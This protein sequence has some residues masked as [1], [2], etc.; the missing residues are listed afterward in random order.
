MF[1]DL[2]AAF[3]EAAGVLLVGDIGVSIA[4]GTGF[5]TYGF[6]GAEAIS[7][8]FI[9]ENPFGA[10]DRPVRPVG[11]PPASGVVPSAPPGAPAAPPAAPAAA[12][13][14]PTA[15]RSP[16]SGPSRSCARRCTPSTGPTAPRA[17]WRRSG[18]S[19]C[20]PPPASRR[21]TGATSAVVSARVRGAA[22]SRRARRER[23]SD[24]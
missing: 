14:R 7:G 10:A 23:P 12:R 6:G 24:A 19:A 5:V 18:C 22:T 8:E 3:C 20:S 2:S 13:R 9:S 16:T 21:S 15:S 4:S 11:P 1:I 17:P